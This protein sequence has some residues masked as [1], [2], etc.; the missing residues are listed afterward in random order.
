MQSAVVARKSRLRLEMLTALAAFGPGQRPG[1][2]A[3]AMAMTSTAAGGR[4][5]TKGTSTGRE[6]NIKNHV[7]FAVLTLKL[8]PF[9]QQ[10]LVLHDHTSITF[11]QAFIHLFCVQELTPVQ[12]L[13]LKV[14]DAI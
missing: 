8:L 5:A 7:S 11:Y 6:C 3:T 14:L 4:K 12:L 2:S 13:P 10:L 1:A 9:L